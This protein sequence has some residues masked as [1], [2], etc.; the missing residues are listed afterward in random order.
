MRAF[1]VDG[2]GPR[3]VSKPPMRTIPLVAALALALASCS[4]ESDETKTSA[5]MEARMREIE[6]RI[7]ES[8]PKTQEAALDQKVAPE[9]VKT[10]Q[11]NLKK[12]NEYQDEPSGKIDD[13]TVNAIQA[14]QRRAGLT[15]DGLLSDRTI[16]KLAE[17]AGAS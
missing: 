13:V 5:A 16:R 3:G 1:L 11:E 15:D 17:A 8:M 14:F 9:V 2:P 4:S 10:C 6:K 7:K 12:L